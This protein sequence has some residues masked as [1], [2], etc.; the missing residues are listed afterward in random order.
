MSNKKVLQ[1]ILEK[2]S[3]LGWAIRQRL[4]CRMILLSLSR[5]QTIT[6]FYAAM[7]IL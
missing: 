3:I 7:L 2:L 5:K 1:E 4:Y 6:R